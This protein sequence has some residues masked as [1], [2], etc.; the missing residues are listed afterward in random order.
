MLLA[1]Q[2]LERQSSG[3][4]PLS[5]ESHEARQESEEQ[6][7][8]VL[9]AHAF[10]DPLSG[11]EGCKARAFGSGRHSIGFSHLS[12][13][14][15]RWLS[16]HH[17]PQQVFALYQ[18]APAEDRGMHPGRLRRER[19]SARMG[20]APGVGGRIDSCMMSGRAM[21]VQRISALGAPGSSRSSRCRGRLVLVAVDAR[22]ADGGHVPFACRSFDG[23]DL[24]C[25]HPRTI[26]HRPASLPPS[27]TTFPL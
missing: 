4:N 27:T 10:Q 26:P 20:S 23:R 18:V 17:E 5:K 16:P 21:R 1:G 9:C 12:M 25:S 11:P 3:A 22:Q 7:N 15:V 2:G 6:G 8:A 13:S 24:A 19:R 14:I